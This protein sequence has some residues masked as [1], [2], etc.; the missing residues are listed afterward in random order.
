MLPLQEFWRRGWQERLNGNGTSCVTRCE[1]AT[2]VFEENWNSVF[3]RQKLAN[4]LSIAHRIHRLKLIAYF[5]FSQAARV[6]RQSELR[7]VR[8]RD[9]FMP[10][11]AIGDAVE[12]AA[13][14]DGIVVA[15][16]ATAE[17]K[18]RYAVESE[19]ALEFVLET[20][21]VPLQTRH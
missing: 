9:T 15:I 1:E 21:L 18:P 13:G 8:T 12:K 3:L 20:E 17:G 10:K 5:K 7:R 16:F 4:H 14:Q 11:F 19:G 2:I 6:V